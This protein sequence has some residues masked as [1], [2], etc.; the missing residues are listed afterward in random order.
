MIGSNKNGDDGKARDLSEP[1]R[2]QLEKLISKEK[3]NLKPRYKRVD[4]PDGIP[5]LKEEQVVN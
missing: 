4:L 5:K 1:Q 3:S 2:Q